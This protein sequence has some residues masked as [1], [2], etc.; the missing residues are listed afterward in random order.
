MP[1]D[2]DE[3]PNC[4]CFNLRKV[5]RVVT[6]FYSAALPG[7]GLLPT[8]T[9][10]LTALQQ[11]PGATMADLSEWLSMDRTTLVRA[12]RPLQQSGLVATDAGGGGRRVTLSLTG[13][14]QRV[15][16]EFMPHWRRVQRKA[17]ATLGP[18]RW[19]ELLGDLDRVAGSLAA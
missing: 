12:L 14:G 19:S 15:L 2:F 4:L 11:H 8:Q 16:K 6:Q 13:E 3:M 17:V 18:E 9:P 5:S 10:I 1:R 7:H